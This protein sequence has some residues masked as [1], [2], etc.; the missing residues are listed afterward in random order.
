MINTESKEVGVIGLGL[1]GSSIVAAMLINGYKVIALA[2]LTSDLDKAP[3]QILHA[4]NES[5]NQG[6]HKH[7]V[8][9]L[10]AN[11]SY[12]GN[13]A[14]L[15]NCFLISECVIENVDIKR[16]IYALIESVVSTNS[17]ITTNT[18]AIPISILQETLAHPERFLGMHWAEPAFT[19]PFLEII[20]G[21]KTDIVIAENLYTIAAAWGKEPTL[22]RK[23]IRGFITNRLMYAMYR[24][25]FNLVENGYASIEDIDRAC[26]N[27]AGHWMTFCGM[28]RYMDLTGLQAYYHVMKDLFPT[29]SN[30]TET[31]RMIE[32]IAKQ[33]GNGISNG[34]GFYTYTKEEAA[35]WKK[36][37][38]E[39][40]YDINLLSLKY[41]IK[42]VEQ[43]LKEKH[44]KD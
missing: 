17:V 39:F 38:E 2:P 18:S 40:S 41:P 32:A 27:D 29:L 7:N 24:E 15:R 12:T 5:F 23:D 13:Y 9:Q 43:R 22:L 44:T 25:G 10:Q 8:S 4:L 30:N 3:G 6:I 14:D 36:A 35:E 31:P 34:N 19:T 26:R 20:C 21:P 1:M 16:N 33:G 37:F 28:F 42:L 11:V